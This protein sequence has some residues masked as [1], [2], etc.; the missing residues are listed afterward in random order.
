M[1]TDIKKI[2]LYK[3][4]MIM[5]IKFPFKK[6]L[7]VMLVMLT[8]FGCTTDDELIENLDISRE[9]APVGLEFFIRTQ[10]TVELHWNTDE[11]VDNYVVEVSENA[12]FSNLVETVNVSSNEVPVQILLAAE[13][14]YY[15][16]VKAVSSRG[17]EDSNWS[18]ITAQTFAEQLFLPIQPGDI[19]Y[20]QATLRWVPN[21]IVTQITVEPGSIVHDITPQ[22]IADGVATIT[23]LSG[24]TTYTAILL[25]GSNV[26]G[27]ISF[28]TEV[29]PSTGTVITPSDNIFQ[30]VT[31]A[32]PG[33]VLILEPGDYTTQVGTITLDKS[34]TIRARYS[35][36]KPM[37][38]VG[39]SIVTGATDVS[40]IDLDLT[41]DSPT[42][43][44]D[45]VRFSAA[46]DFN[47][48]LIRGCNVHDYDRSF[49][50]GNV[51]G[52]TVNSVEINNCVVTNVITIGGDFIDF[53]NT[54][55]LNISVK[56]STFNNC[57]PARDFFRVDAA[58][59]LNGSA[60]VSVLLESCTLYACSNNSSRRIFYVRF[61]SNE[62]TSR[63]NLITDTVVEA[64]SDQS[65]TDETIVFDN[66]N[67][68]NAPTLYDTTVPRFDTSTT[69]LMLDP[70]F[71]DPASGD[72]TVTNQTIVDNQI[73]DPRW[74]Q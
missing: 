49:V 55:A 48:L 10:T 70:G 42:N 6:I 31:D 74:L 26:R 63:N 20:N 66:N 40:L 45:V 16:R 29:D 41:G 69:Y 13:T 2:E 56:N 72:F 44:T 5:K 35:Y 73:G 21:S 50:A 33:D 47:S 65:S 30:R 36:D 67:Y 57:A 53:R 32:S 17:L 11:N 25:N 28:T 34:L 14:F 37:L 23:G 61:D 52:A 54:N 4:L 9:F 8:A 15:I 22:E 18:T 3:K 1:I 62:I 68:F 59:N 12:D 38:K 71:V 24:E 60:T 64:Y 7:T 43:L 39:V 19:L 46:G 27:G 51:T 58:G